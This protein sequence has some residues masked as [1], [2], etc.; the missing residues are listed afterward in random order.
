MFSSTLN[1]YKVWH[2]PSSTWKRVGLKMA[3]DPIVTRLLFFSWCN[4]KCSTERCSAFW[5]CRMS[6]TKLWIWFRDSDFLP[7]TFWPHFKLLLSTP[8]SEPLHSFNLFPSSYYFPPRHPP[9][10]MVV[11]QTQACC[12]R[13]MTTKP[14]E[15]NKPLRQ[16]VLFATLLQ[17]RLGHL[18]LAASKRNLGWWIAAVLL[19]SLSSSLLRLRVK[20]WCSTLVRASQEVHI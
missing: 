10:S 3:R 7:R 2:M 15:W 1:S 12:V 19:R 17:L 16:E 14:L 20:Q 8:V 6:T 11:P 4:A 9:A 13:N 5:M 18:K